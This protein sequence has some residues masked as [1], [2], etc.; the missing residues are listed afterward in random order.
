MPPFVGQLDVR[1]AGGGRPGHPAHEGRNVAWMRVHPPQP[2]DHLALTALSDGWMPAAMSKLGRLVVV[3]TL[4]LTIH[5]RAPAPVDADWLLA[6]YSS[7]FS[8]GGAW[9]EDGELW[10]QDGRLVGQSRQL[11]MIRERR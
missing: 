3:P 5:F 8:A 4:D 7:R 11:A 10:T 2:F 1:W 6:V 9:E